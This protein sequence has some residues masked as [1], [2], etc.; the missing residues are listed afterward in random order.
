MPKDDKCDRSFEIY[1]DVLNELSAM[2][3]LYGGYYII[4]GRDFDVDFNRQSRNADLLKLLL[5]EENLI[6]PPLSSTRATYTY[7]STRGN[8]YGIDHFIVNESAIGV[9]ECV[10][11]FR[12]GNNLTE[13]LPISVTS[14][15]TANVS[16]TERFIQPSVNWEK[17]FTHRY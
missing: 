9:G 17:S 1:G 7:E 4:I 16:H 13:H 3:N 15:L 5:N 14:T 6:C 8:R 2:I 12:D 10:S 11:T